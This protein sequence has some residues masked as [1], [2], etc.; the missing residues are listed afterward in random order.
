MPAVI[1]RAL[2][3]RQRQHHRKA[4]VR[5]LAEERARADARVEEV[6][7]ELKAQL[8]LVQQH[9]AIAQQVADEPTNEQSNEIGWRGDWR[10]ALGPSARG[11]RKSGRRSEV[12]SSGD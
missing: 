4:A 10:I 9:V 1:V 2:A 6:R 7:R 11:P 3:Y 5:E 12:R 8:A